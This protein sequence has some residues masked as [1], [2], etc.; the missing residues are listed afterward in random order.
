M[1]E[2]TLIEAV[3]SKQVITEA[4]RNLTS[5]IPVA[6]PAF[7]LLV[8]RCLRVVPNP[9]LADLVTYKGLA[10]PKDLPILVA[11]LRE[12]CSWLVTFNERHYR[13]GHPAVSV[14]RPG[15]FL[16]HVRDRLSRLT[17]R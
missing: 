16:L 15:A 8:A 14:L 11:S 3:A 7:R 4:E 5:K 10:D 12:N 1:A 2:I 13:P 17:G 6:L 9:E